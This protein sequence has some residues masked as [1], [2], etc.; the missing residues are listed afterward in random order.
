MQKTVLCITRGSR[1]TTP[2]SISVTG[3]RTERVHIRTY[4]PHL[5]RVHEYHRHEV[6]IAGPLLSHLLDMVD[7]FQISLPRAVL[8]RVVVPAPRQEGLK[9]D[10]H[11]SK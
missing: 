8:E 11:A 5:L 2:G 4:A 10:Q 7:E 9:I 6:F 1:D 3:K